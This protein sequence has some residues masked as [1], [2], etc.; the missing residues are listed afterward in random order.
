[1]TRAQWVCSE[2]ESNTIVAIVKHLGLIFLDGA[3][4]KC[5]NKFK[6][7]KEALKKATDKQVLQVHVPVL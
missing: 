6:K 5:S 1:M 3:F 7:I 2:A 4:D